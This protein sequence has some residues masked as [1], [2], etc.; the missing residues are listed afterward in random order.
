MRGWSSGGGPPVAQPHRA[1]GLSIASTPYRSAISRGISARW[2][3]AWV[4]TILKMRRLS[5]AH[6]SSIARQYNQ[7]R[8]IAQTANGFQGD[9]RDVIFINPCRGPDMPGGSLGLH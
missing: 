2:R 6:A 3:A 4:G 9:P 5:P 1:S 8:L 7:R